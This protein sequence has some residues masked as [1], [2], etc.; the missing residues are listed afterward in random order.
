MKL[1]VK[2]T[3]D[4]FFT[5]HRDDGGAVALLCLAAILSLMLVAWVIIDA[6]KSSHDKIALQGA[7]D[8]AAM[9]QASVKAR[10][11]NMVSY[12]NIAKRSVVGIHSLYP[13]MFFGFTLFVLSQAADCFKIFPNP[14]ACYKFFRDAPKWIWEFAMD[15]RRYSGDPTRPYREAASYGLS[16]IPVVGKIN[17]AIGKVRDKI[18]GVGWL[19]DLLNSLLGGGNTDDYYGKDIQAIDNYQ[20]YMQHV[21]PWWAWGEQLSKGWRNGAT[22][23]AS[24][25]APPGDVTRVMA[26]VQN[27]INRINSVLA[28]VGAGSI[29]FTTFSGYYDILPIQKNE[30]GVLKWLGHMIGGTSNFGSLDW[31]NLG[32]ESFVA[33]H[34]ANIWQHRRNS[35]GGAKGWMTIGFG[36]TIGFATIGMAYSMS[37]FKDAASPHIIN[38]D[39]INDEA[40]WLTRTSN[41]IF[42]YH[43][44][45]TRMDEDRQKLSVPPKEY[46]HAVGGIDDFFYKSSGYWTMAKS[47]ISYN[48]PSAPDMWHPSWT[49]RMR[50]VHLPDEFN[51]AG[52]SM[53]HSYHDVLPYLALTAQ[54]ASV[55]G[56]GTIDQV[57]SSLQDFLIMELSTRSM[58]PSTIDGVAK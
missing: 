35:S 32:N 13:G 36:S 10:T 9:S 8:M 46:E 20:H 1:S 17:D 14:S 57:L 43:N 47:E 4:F 34:A 25:P 40:Q 16:A 15:H 52:Y 7:A 3:R 21:T 31:N 23:T 54:V 24:F 51:D 56:G 38:T 6:G 27:I 49:A 45:T 29:D 48:G 19:L 2:K 42:A 18:P 33:E 11:M 39:L 44:D 28:I 55:R 50:P 30:W 5:A 37:A 41:L 53:N 26:F 12:A 58:G 22:T